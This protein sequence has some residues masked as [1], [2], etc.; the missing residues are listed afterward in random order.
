MIF[1]N[2]ETLFVFEVG[3][4]YIYVNILVR[5]QYIYTSEFQKI[6]CMKKSLEKF[7]HES[8]QNHV[9]KLLET[10]LIIDNLRKKS[11]KKSLGSSCRFS[12]LIA[13]NKIVSLASTLQPPHRSLQ[14]RNPMI[15]DLNCDHN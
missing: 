10:S 5:H 4:N 8:I 3:V 11:K 14:S 15:T 9:R 1:S 2:S 13:R 7:C 12:S 6:K